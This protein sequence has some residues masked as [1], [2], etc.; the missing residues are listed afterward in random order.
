M[1]KDLLAPNAEVILLHVI[2]PARSQIVE[3]HLMSSDQLEENERAKAIDYL[4]EC[5]DRAEGSHEGWRQEVFVGQSVG[6]A[7]VDVVLLRKVDLVAMY[8][9]DRKGLAKFIMGSTAKE[10]KREGPADVKVFTPSELEAV[11]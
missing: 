7:I 10:V 2:P 9:H 6:Q 1:I 11:T 8:T 5:M 3:G 4:Q